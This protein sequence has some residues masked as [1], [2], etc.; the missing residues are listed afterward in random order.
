MDDDGSTITYKSDNHLNKK[1]EAKVGG[2][3]KQVLCSLSPSCRAVLLGLC[4]LSE[5]RDFM[6]KYRLW[7]AGLQQ[8]RGVCFAAVVVVAEFPGN[9]VVHFESQGFK[10]H[11]S[12]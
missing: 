12:F 9:A 5:Q 8:S 4:H 11:W 3:L 2:A 7:S 10:A 6:L 1:S